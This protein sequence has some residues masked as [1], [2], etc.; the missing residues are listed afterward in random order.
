MKNRTGHAGFFAALSCVS[1][2]AVFGCG[3]SGGSEDSVGVTDADISEAGTDGSSSEDGPGDSAMLDAL[4]DGGHEDGPGD[5]ALPDAEAE[6]DLSDDGFDDSALPDSGTEDVSPS[7]LDPRLAAPVN[8]AIDLH[9]DLV[10]GMTLACGTNVMWTAG[11]L[12]TELA[13]GALAC[14]DY[15]YSRPFA[16]RFDDPSILASSKYS[17]RASATVDGVPTYT[18]D[19]WAVTGLQGQ[20]VLP[21]CTVT[22]M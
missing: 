12:D 9:Y 21:T 5:S 19:C 10:F 2:L 8:V 15:T 20:A 6:G 18:A 1:M 11:I 3:T 16:I 4:A 7:P 14:Y 22:A 13:T 17:L